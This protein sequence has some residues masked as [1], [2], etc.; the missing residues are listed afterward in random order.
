MVIGRHLKRC[1]PGS[2]E[3]DP[4]PVDGSRWYIKDFFGGRT[5]FKPV[6]PAR[7][8]VMTGGGCDDGNA[9][10][11]KFAKSYAFPGMAID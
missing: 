2:D 6:P 10:Y 9:H 11:D 4:R 1:L 7:D 3:R 8:A 5:S